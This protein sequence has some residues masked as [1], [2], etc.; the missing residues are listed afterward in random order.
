MTAFD[1]NRVA[2]DLV[3]ELTGDP[4]LIAADYDTYVPSSGIVTI[5]PGQTVATFTVAII[6]DP[7]YEDF[8]E[9]F[10]VTLTGPSGAT[11]GDIT[12]AAVTVLPSD[13]PPILSVAAVNG[14]EGIDEG[15]SARFIFTLEPP[16]CR[17]YRIQR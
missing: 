3:R 10:F 1:S 4:G 12:R 6:D 5:P 16:H 7:V 2:R 14:E 13:T 8:P 15:G 9:A 11:L 17:L